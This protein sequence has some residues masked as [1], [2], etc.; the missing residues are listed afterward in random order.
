MCIT[1]CK[2][3]CI[4][5]KLFYFIV[6]YFGCCLIFFYNYYSEAVFLCFLGNFLSLR[7]ARECASQSNE[8]RHC[9]LNL[10]RCKLRQFANV[11]M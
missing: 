5:R 4:Y 2:F 1:N 11:L 3:N 7:A 9:K 6:N 10:V 8:K